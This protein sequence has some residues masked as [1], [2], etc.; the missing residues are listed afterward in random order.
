MD[1]STP[2]AVPAPDSDPDPRSGQGAGGPVG[3]DLGR[4]FTTAAF[5]AAGHSAVE[6][7]R[8]CYRQVLRSVWV[9]TEAV[10]DDTPIR[11]ALALHPASAYASHF[12]AARLWG[13]PV[14]EHPF[15]H[16]TVVKACHRRPRPGLKTHVTG[17]G[18]AVMTARGV[19][20]TP[21]VV[22]FIQLAGSLALVDLVVLGDALVARRGVTAAQLRAACDRSTEYYAAAAREAAAY[23]RDGVDSPQE[24]R[25]RLLIVLAGLPEPTVNVV[26]R[27]DDGSWW[28][29]FDL[30]YE[31]VRLVIEYDGRQHA[32]DARQWQSDLVRREELDDAGYRILVVTASGLFAEPGRTLERIRRQLVERGWPDVPPLDE[33]WKRHFPT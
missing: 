1:R 29:R 33:T 23:V 11:A 30:C 12:S 25:T 24:T 20:A 26:L 2:P 27:H 28:R 15:E 13:L 10:D 6:L 5:L 4:P 31:L 3:L 22:T 16:V 18:R 7:R 21:P 19:R 14:P 32:D 17:R 9:H 8:R